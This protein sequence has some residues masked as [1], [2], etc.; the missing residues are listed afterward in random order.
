MEK[1]TNDCA[2]K[3][4]K[5]GVDRVKEIVYPVE[6]DNFDVDAMQTQNIARWGETIEFLSEGVFAKLG[7]EIQSAE[8]LN[9]HPRRRDAF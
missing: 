1:P 4:L 7:L 6:R 8:S 5:S 3:M 9:T 2:C